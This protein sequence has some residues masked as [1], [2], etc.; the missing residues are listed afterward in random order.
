MPIQ[1]ALCFW[2]KL[3]ENLRIVHTSN[4]DPGA[5]LYRLTRAT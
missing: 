5:L 3:E 1:K 4:L 2:F